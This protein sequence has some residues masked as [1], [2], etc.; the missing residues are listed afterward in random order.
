[1]II[2]VPPPTREALCIGVTYTKVLIE[3][4]TSSEPDLYLNPGSESPI[5][6]FETSFKALLSNII[7][8]SSLIA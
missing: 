8:P 5:N 2:D 6:T 3:K 1:M 4:V 7:I